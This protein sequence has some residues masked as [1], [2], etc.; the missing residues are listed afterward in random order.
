MKISERQWDELRAAAEADDC[1]LF[2]RLLS[3]WIRIEV[4]CERGRQRRCGIV[5]DFEQGRNQYFC[6]DR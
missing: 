2:Q 4:A 1:E 5:R 6:L 3:E